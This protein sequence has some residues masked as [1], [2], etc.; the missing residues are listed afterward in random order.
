MKLAVLTL[1]AAAGMA[2]GA[3]TNLVSTRDVHAW[4]TN[5]FRPWLTR[6]YP[7]VT[8]R[9]YPDW[10]QEHPPGLQPGPFTNWLMEVFPDIETEMYPTW[11][12]NPSEAALGTNLP[13]WWTT[14]LKSRRSV[15]PPAQ[16]VPTIVRGPYLQLR[17]TNS[18]V[19]RWRMDIP[20]VS[21]LSD[22]A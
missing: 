16:P 12:E 14:V 17:T 6:T 13:P 7:E 2:F 22:R 11:M 20:A 8:T 19:V 10:L 4:L 9:F 3:E 1:L 21:R 5:T 18:M 15:S